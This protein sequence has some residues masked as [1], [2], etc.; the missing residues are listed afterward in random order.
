LCPNCSTNIR[1]VRTW[2]TLIPASALHLGPRIGSAKRWK[3]RRRAHIF[4]RGGA[5]SDWRNI[6]GIAAVRPEQNNPYCG[7]SI[8]GT[9]E[10]IPVR[11]Y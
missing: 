3:T 10:A 1:P 5:Q 8:D 2:P 6:E 9:R 4:Q 7:A 11:A